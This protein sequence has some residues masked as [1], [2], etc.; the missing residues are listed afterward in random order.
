MTKHSFPS[1][2]IALKISTGGNSAA[3]G[4]SGHN[5]GDISST[6]TI[7]Y[8]PTNKA[9]GSDVHVTTGDK[10]YQKADW[11]AG[12]ANAKAEWF[13]KAYGGDATSN[14]SQS[15]D[16]GHDMSKVYADTTATQSN[17]FYADQSQNVMAGNGGDGGYGAAMGGNVDLSDVL[18]HS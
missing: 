5:S 9:Y 8:D 13:S 2:T 16:S 4:G 6:P 11:D 7:N 15:S 12:G 18:N 17:D 14:G 3:N 1:D 10:V